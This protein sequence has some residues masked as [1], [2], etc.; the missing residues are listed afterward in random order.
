MN[1]KDVLVYQI[2]CGTFGRH[3]LRKFFELEK[4]LNVNLK[5]EGVC[6]VDS[7]ARKLAERIAGEFG[8]RIKTFAYTYDMY[9][10]AYEKQK[11]G[12]AILIYDASPSH[13]HASHFIKSM[14]HN[15]FHI[16]EKPLAMTKEEFTQVKMASKTYQK[17]ILCDFIESENEVVLTAINYLE[18]HKSSIKS[19][20]IF[21]E[22]SIGIQKILHPEHRLAVTGGDILDKLCHEIYLF[23]FVEA[24]RSRVID[25]KVLDASARYLMINSLTDEH[26]LDI[27]GAKTEKISAE[28]P[29]TATAQSKIKCAAYLS[30]REK[31]PIILHSSWFGVS[32]EGKRISELIKKGTGKCVIEKKAIT[33]AHRFYYENLRLF[34]VACD[35][36]ALYGDMKNKRLIVNRRGKWEE[37]ELLKFEGDQLYRILK[38]AVL[39]AAGIEKPKIKMHHID[40]I[41]RIVFGGMEIALKK[42]VGCEKTEMEKAKKYVEG[43]LR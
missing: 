32:E 25:V 17:P 31:V 6:D 11:E 4:D 43:K 22:C 12:H 7:S 33:D 39:V 30:S 18:Q 21:R 5:V 27:Y 29:L 28:N 24:N 38:N 15:F 41:H 14:H 3:G 37:I 42:K 23:D 35:D 26:F 19:I 1:M 20:E 2:G 10:D 34:V 40:L 9:R 8:R 16:A 13:L 36:F